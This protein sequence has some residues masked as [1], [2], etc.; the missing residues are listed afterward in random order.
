MPSFGKTSLSRLNTCHKDLKRVLSEA[1]K[2]KDFSVICG[3]RGEEE[4]N[5]AYYAGYSTL[6]YPQSMHNSSPSLAV[7]IW[8]YDPVIKEALSGHPTQITRIMDKTGKNESEVKA[9][10]R[11]EF[12]MLMGVVQAVAYYQGVTLRFGSDWD[13]DGYRL[14]QS[15][16]DLPHIELKKR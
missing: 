8:P 16:D 14:D 10:I 9:Y 6:K 13:G 4:Q 5:K 2:I 3:E 15:F 11:E 1:I 12:L 7:D